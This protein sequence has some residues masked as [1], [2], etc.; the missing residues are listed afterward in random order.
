MNSSQIFEKG[1]IVR[2]RDDLTI[3]DFINI[4]NKIL[5][6]RMSYALIS[7]SPKIYGDTFDNT[8]VQ[9]LNIVDEE[10]LFIKIIDS[11]KEFLIN[12]CLFIHISF[13]DKNLLRT[14][15]VDKNTEKRIRRHDNKLKNSNYGK[16]KFFH[17]D[18]FKRE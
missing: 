16:S 17:K 1:D 3:E 14:I 10:Y 5:V 15:F 13:I 2:L 11:D 9:I 8:Y 18:K 4:K 12:R 7:L 6:N